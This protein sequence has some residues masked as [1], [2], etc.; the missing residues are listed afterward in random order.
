MA[1]HVDESSTPAYTMGY[2]EEFER[3]LRR[4]TADTH[5]GY[6]LPHLKP[7]MRMLD[8]G[9]GPGTISVGLAGAV[10]PGEFFGVDMDASQVDLA[11]KAAREG[12]H[13]NAR[14]RVA[15][16]LDLPF[17]DDHFD[18]VHCH[19]VLMHIPDTRA[20]LAE[21]T[22]VLRTGGILGAR[23]YIGDSS[24][25]EPD[26]GNLNECVAMYSSLVTAN[27]GQP[28]MGKQLRA[29]ISDAG[30]VDVEASASF[31]NFGSPSDV[32]ALGGF[33]IEY[34]FGPPIADQAIA[35]GL[36]TRED[37]DGWRD[38]VPGWRDHP[39]AIAALAWGEAIGHKP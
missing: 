29:K 32:A 1:E 39:G 26:A 17:P 34:L 6:L 15:D 20:A 18:V 4:R 33:L 28:Q 24:F 14:F 22:R 23:E 12:G 31:E 16:A 38:A 11:S 3:F 13:S 36:A 9:C 8:I 25:I 5:A 2:A 10:D 37:F 19:A 7:G 27:G 30:F 35:H 21:V